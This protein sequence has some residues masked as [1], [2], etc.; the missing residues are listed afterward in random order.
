MNRK[1]HPAGHS[2]GN[3]R[4]SAGWRAHA[5]TASIAI[6]AILATHDMIVFSGVGAT[7]D[8]WRIAAWTVAAHL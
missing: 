2:V 8:I 4:V 1:L 7:G 6:A 3:D 5:E